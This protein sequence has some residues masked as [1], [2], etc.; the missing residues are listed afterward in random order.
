MNFFSNLINDVGSVFSDAG[1]RIYNTVT[2]TIPNFFSNIGSAIRDTISGT[3]P[4]SQVANAVNSGPYSGI[5][6]VNPQSGQPNMTLNQ[7]AGVPA[8]TTR[9]GAPVAINPYGTTNT[10]GTLNNVAQQG[11]SDAMS[12]YGFGGGSLPRP[13]ITNYTPGAGGGQYSFGPQ[14]T[15]QMGN[16]YTTPSGQLIIPQVA[17]GGQSGVGSG[18]NSTTPTTGSPG[19]AGGSANSGTLGAA[20]FGVSSPFAG[21]YQTDEEKAKAKKIQ[22]IFGPLDQATSSSAVPGITPGTGIGGITTPAT[23]GIPGMN[24][25][26]TTTRPTFQAPTT[27]SIQDVNALSAPTNPAMN[28]SHATAVDDQHAV[29]TSIQNNYVVEKQKLDQQYPA[30]GNLTTDTPEQ[31]AAIDG[32]G[33]PYGVKAALDA[34][35]ASN[36]QLLTLETQRL[37]VLK[38]IQALTAAYNP[39]IQDIKSNP[40]LPKGL[41]AR[42]LTDLNEKQKNVLLGFQNQ[43]ELLN[44]AIGDQNQA[45][46]RAFQIAQFSSSTAEKATDNARQLL[47]TMVTTGAIGG[48]SDKELSQLASKTGVPLSGLIKARTVA[49]DP[50]KNIETITDDAG[51]L[52]GVDKLSGKTI[53]TIKG[54]GKSSPSTS[55]TP[56]GGSFGGAST[57]NDP[58]VSWI[59]QAAT[60]IA[61]T[62][63]AKNQREA[64]TNNINSAL[65]SGNTE[66]AKTQ[67]K[68][69]VLDKVFSTDQRNDFNGRADA[70]ANL[71]AISNRLQSDPVNFGPYKTAA[72][73]VKPFFFGKKDQKYVEVQ[74][75]IENSQAIIRKANYGTAVTSTE[76]GNANKYLINGKDDASTVATKLAGLSNF[77]KWAN[78]ANLARAVGANVPAYTLVSQQGGSSG[79][80]QLDSLRSKYNY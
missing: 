35:K 10:V 68:T 5:P 65:K 70:I 62:I 40:D 76:A 79:N 33:D 34:Y 48:M 26:P 61:N 74:Q 60:T 44:T 41:A 39:I 50:V 53:W 69:Y 54:A 36:T 28:T 71:D 8:P 64:F 14:S 16:P 2:N 6:G 7:A 80:Q 18:F 57:S 15:P 58:S 52:R 46:N 27:S 38:S 37:D 22:D 29:N 55:G 49:N 42:R 1:N 20:G 47:N 51:T 30:N 21:L 11:R 12:S 9:S 59:G 72:E 23:L 31:Q 78:E 66:F 56:E 73:L 75:A 67:V 4:A 63:S 3:N 25:T 24:I 32:S 77:M 43:L 19:L 13:A 45:V 17:F